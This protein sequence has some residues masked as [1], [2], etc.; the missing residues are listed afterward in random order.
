MADEDQLAK[1]GRSLEEEY[2]RR[3]DR[4]LIEKVREAAAIEQARGELGRRTGL[5]DP[6]LLDQLRDLGFTPETVTLL[7]LVPVLEMAWAEGG[8][9]DAERDLILQIA[10]NRGVQDDSPAGQQ[11]KEWLVHRPQPVVFE[12]A[13]RLVSAM[14]SSGAEGVTGKLTADELVAY[15]ERIASASGGV[16]GL[17]RVSGEERA[18]LSRI[19]SDLK[20]RKS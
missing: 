16:F 7:P 11:L 14:L 4:E 1:R 3:K 12:R 9:T 18:L 5:D 8:V 10:R 6:A 2:F 20:A 19:A 13:G 15:C 17:G